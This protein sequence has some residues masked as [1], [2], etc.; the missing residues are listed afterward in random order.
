MPAGVI[1]GWSVL[2]GI[3]WE[4]YKLF[5]KSKRSQSMEMVL[6]SVI[7]GTHSGG[8]LQFFVF[9]FFFL[10]PEQST[11]GRTSRI[12]RHPS[13]PTVV[14]SRIMNSSPHKARTSRL[15]SLEIHNSRLYSMFSLCCMSQGTECYGQYIVHGR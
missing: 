1:C 13:T 12:N 5:G 14:F 8:H 3:I 7:N 10:T 15:Q 2:T 4:C 11:Q 9:F 6:A